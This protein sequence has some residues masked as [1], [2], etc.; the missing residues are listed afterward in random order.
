[1]KYIAIFIFVISMSTMHAQRQTTDNLNGWFMYFGDHKFADKWGV[2][3]EAQLR[4]NDIVMNGQQLLLRTG[5]NYHLNSNIFFTAGYCFVQTDPYGEFPVK[6]SYPEHR[7]WEQMQIKTQLQNTEWTGRFRL[8]QRF[9]QLPVNM[10]GVWTPDTAVYTN[11]FRLLNRFS[12]PFKGSKIEDKS[13]YITAYDELFINFGERVGMNLLD[14]NRAYIALGY[15]IPKIG[16]L[17][18]GY[19][20]QTIIKP[21]GLQV[22]YNHTLQVGLSSTLDFRKTKSK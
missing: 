22:E 1:M 16:R 6:A 10:A 5:L 21:S 13:L 2:H 4:R 15:K 12:M 17:E 11:R 7:L 18:V 20:Q 8:E 14:Q 9:S 3:I 19:M